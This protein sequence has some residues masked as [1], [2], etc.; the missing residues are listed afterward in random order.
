MY[1]NT[2][3][4]TPLL[5]PPPT[6]S[7]SLLPTGIPP[8]APLTAMQIGHHNYHHQAQQQPPMVQ[9]LYG[10]W[11]QQSTSVPAGL[12]GQPLPPQRQV[13]EAGHGPVE[14]NPIIQGTRATSQSNQGPQNLAG[15][16][17]KDMYARLG[18]VSVAINNE[19]QSSTSFRKWVEK[20]FTDIK[21]EIS[22][23]PQAIAHEVG[24]ARKDRLVKIKVKKAK[25]MIEQKI[26][27]EELKSAKKA[28]Q[29]MEN[30]EA[31]Q[32]SFGEESNG[33]ESAN[34]SKESEE[35]K[36]D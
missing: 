9:P 15:P 24:K 14:K 23:L 20:E 17:L 19:C 21:E 2:Y 26:A 22:R 32:S 25:K 16:T 34:Q 10:Q 12:R 33:A 11:A 6:T 13:F 3:Q 28:D 31:G 8:Q 35:G 29:N 5:Q 36:M 27:E 1:L 30:N 4:P 18:K 7:Q